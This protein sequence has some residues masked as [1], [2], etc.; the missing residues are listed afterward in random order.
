MKGLFADTAPAV[1]KEAGSLAMVHIDCDIYDAVKVSYDLSKPHMVPMGYYVFDDATVS[2]CIG[3]AEAVE[4]LVIQRDGL[5][6]EQIFPHFVFRKP[7]ARDALR[8]RT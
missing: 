1:L 6:S 2:S 4:E 7:A 5:F 3:A 8:L